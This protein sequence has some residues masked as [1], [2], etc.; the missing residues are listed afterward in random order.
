MPS[1]LNNTFIDQI[2][3]GEAPPPSVLPNIALH[4]P[5]TVD[6]TNGGNFASFITDGDN[7]NSEWVSS[8]NSANKWCE[9]NFG[10]SYRISRYIVYTENNPYSI[11][12]FQFQKW[13]ETSQS[14]IT[15]DAV[16]GN[17]SSVVDRAVVAFDASKVRLYIT[18]MT[19]NVF[20]DTTAR[21]RELEVYG[22]LPARLGPGTATNIY[23]TSVEAKF[24]ATGD[25]I[26]FDGLHY[27]PKPVTSTT[28]Q[29]I[30]VVQTTPGELQGLVLKNGQ[31]TPT[32][33]PGLT[34]LPAVDV[35][36][37]KTVT[38]S[39]FYDNSYQP[40]FA[41]NG[42]DNDEW[43]SH[44]G[45]SAPHTLEVDLGAEYPV[46]RWRF[47][48]ATDGNTTDPNQQIHNMQLQY[49]SVNTWYDADVV[50]NN[51]SRQ[52]TRDFQV[53]TARNWRLYI[54]VAAPNDGIAR[55]G[56]L[57]LYVIPIEPVVLPD[58]DPSPAGTYNWG[59]VNA[60]GL[61]LTGNDVTGGTGGAGSTGGSTYRNLIATPP[62]SPVTG[63]IWLPPDGLAEGRFNDPSWEFFGPLFKFY[64]PILSDFTWLNQGSATIT[65]NGVGLYLN[66]PAGSINIR[67]IIKP[68]PATPYSIDTYILSHIN[69]V[70]FNKVGLLWYDSNSG[71][72]VN[73]CLLWDSGPKFSHTVF[74]SVDSW[75]GHYGQVSQS[76]YAI[77]GTNWMQISDDGTTRNCS[78]SNDGKHWTTIL[79]SAH[80]QDITPTHVGFFVSSESSSSLG[81][82]LLSWHES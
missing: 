79:N 16:G 15:V 64:P 78:I 43:A 7:A 34:I 13:D 74:N 61:V 33:I 58:L 51:T 50:V 32:N 66:A 76:Q 71:K 3:L 1:F 18:K 46:S 10:E 45:A 63:D 4:K 68:A 36:L 37:N 8:N 20:G 44:S 73:F 12:D 9:I 77:F 80:A 69:P 27:T 19:N 59:Q 82:T 52:F 38:A 81:G 25:V 35:A 31:Y 30:P 5:V 26:T 23:G 11:V 53:V 6:S 72:V 47:S 54:T 28:I 56:S 55:V 49:K 40:G 41:V 62:V 75:A 70:S 48:G 24:P 65:Q 42:N 14:Y 29:G 2:D 17:T 39:S 67:G 21:V 60:Q 57:N 22:Y